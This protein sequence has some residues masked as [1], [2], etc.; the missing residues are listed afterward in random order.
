MKRWMMLIGML[1]LSSLF[2]SVNVSEPPT[3]T[4]DVAAIVNATLTA[5]VAGQPTATPTQAMV[6]ATATPIAMMA[7]MND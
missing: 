2:C 4:V 3:P 6:V 7:P 5:F 1:A